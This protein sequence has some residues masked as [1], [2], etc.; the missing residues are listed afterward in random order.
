[1]PIVIGNSNQMSEKAGQKIRIRDL[2]GSYFCF[3]GQ[4]SK[5]RSSRPGLAA[6]ASPHLV[7][8]PEFPTEDLAL[9]KSE[10]DPPSGMPTKDWPR[11]VVLLDRVNKT[12]CRNGRVV[13][14]SNETNTDVRMYT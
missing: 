11:S 12:L 2:E 1:M 8:S 13:L 10:E 3:T 5:P 6:L 14:V 9:L 7:S 4:G